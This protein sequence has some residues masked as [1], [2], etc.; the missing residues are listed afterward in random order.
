V[1]VEVAAGVTLLEV[2]DPHV[3]VPLGSAGALG[4]EL[5]ELLGA[6]V[7]DDA[8]LVDGAAL[9]DVEVDGAPVVVDDDGC[10]DCVDDA[11]DDADDDGAAEL[12]VL[13]ELLE[14]PGLGAV[15][16]PLGCALVLDPLPGL[17]PVP[18]D[19]GGPGFTGGG[20]GWPGSVTGRVG[21]V[22]GGCGMISVGSPLA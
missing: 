4:E 2:V 7:E 8:A 14:P 3:A 19:R 22:T 9:V 20:T 21:A 1:S 17:L 16:V 6:L 15:L 18:P 12:D 5:S 10:P 11:D 13:D